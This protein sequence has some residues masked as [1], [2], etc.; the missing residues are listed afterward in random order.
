MSN[1]HV[2]AIFLLN[3]ISKKLIT[4][5]YIV[6]FF[7]F[8]NQPLKIH[9]LAETICIG[10]FLNKNANIFAWGYCTVKLRLP[11]Y[12]NLCILISYVWPLRVVNMLFRQRHAISGQVQGVGFR[13]Y[14]YRLAIKHNLT[15]FV[16]N[17][18]AG[19][20]IELQG[21][22]SGLKSFENDITLLPP[23]AKVY[24]HNVEQIEVVKGETQ[25]QIVH[26]AAGGD[27][28]AIVSPDIAT[29]ADCLKDITNPENRR[30][31]YPFT[32]CTNCGPRYSITRSLP[33]DRI[34]TS[35]SQFK[36]CRSCTR[37]Y[38][39]PTNRRFHAQPNACP[40]CGPRVWITNN[41]G[42]YMAGD[43]LSLQ[44]AVRKLA[45]GK[46]LA[47]KSLGGF[48]L[49]CCATYSDTIVKLRQWK[50]RPS[51]PMAVM[52]PNMNT[53]KEIAIVND[54][55]AELLLG[56]ERPIVLC[57]VLPDS[58]LPSIISPDSSL[59][60][61][62]LPYTPLQHILFLYFREQAPH[63]SPVFIMTSGN[64]H[65]EP[66]CTD[67]KDALNKLSGIADFFL[68]HDQDIAIRTDDS[69]ILPLPVDIS[70]HSF[71]SKEK[72]SHM[73]FFRRSRGYAPSPV[74]MNTSGPSV[75]G[76]GAEIKS[77]VCLTRGMQA[78][79]SQHIGDI[80]SL[81]VYNFFQDLIAHLKKLLQI[82]PEAIVADLHP[83][84]KSANWA[85]Q[86]G[87]PVFRLQ[88]HFAHI[89]AVLAERRH[90]TPVIGLAL[91]GTGYGEDG[92]IW[93]G[94]C[95]F[96][97]PN[98]LEQS[99]IGCLDSFRLPGGDAAVLNPW[100]FAVGCLYDLGIL[101]LG[102]RDSWPW[103]KE[104][105]AAENL[106]VGML[107]KNFNCPS[108][109]SCGRL[110]DAVSALCGFSQTIS[111]EGQAAIL[112]E[113][114]QAFEERESYPCPLLFPSE[115]GLLESPDDGAEEGEKKDGL[116]VLNTGA[117][118]RAVAED[119]LKG[120]PV[121]SISRR[122]HLGLVNGLV[123]MATAAADRTGISTV[124]LS[125]G[126]MQNV[127]IISELSRALR[128]VGLVPLAH[129]YLPPNDGCISLGQAA[130]GRLLLGV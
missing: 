83:D 9:P 79:V 128:R 121:W 100:Q 85:L 19:V 50:K 108:T 90:D 42:T 84:F 60:G 91:D 12:H 77:S 112:L 82:E 29:C 89:R 74:L 68:L 103:R 62:M 122:F 107:E 20:L 46:I 34:N 57:P 47:I 55:A 113:K 21:T 76:V 36:M 18:A 101:E 98:S 78:F 117:L 31:L 110:F 32:N 63:L 80:T 40:L 66:I 17:T 7:K 4:N 26:S 104:H 96:V 48:H 59:L 28:G 116:L 95:L 130:Y 16:R 5:L 58:F 87:L 124:V 52:V 27:P 88:H 43:G 120:T 22:S 1:R 64:Q 33:Y 114:S 56:N 25:F 94:E 51:K 8:F 49:A 81:E 86:Q 123:K 119:V 10:I 99:R 71:G 2:G 115:A 53:A 127:T 67:N 93:G 37:E 105:A 44:T 126:V 45:D 118:I 111:Y 125:G 65:G 129:S 35:M 15:G 6:L 30:C 24:G 13:P 106:I 38:L 109:T 11:H 69:V 70:T 102:Q 73:V 54:F 39:D 72:D 14:V 41:F 23:L 3:E 92:T 75:L 61:I 97:D